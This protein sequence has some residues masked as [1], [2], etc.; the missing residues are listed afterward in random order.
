MRGDRGGE[1]SAEEKSGEGG[2]P[3][4]GWENDLTL[5]WEEK[6]NDVS[7]SPDFGVTGDADEGAEEEATLSREV[8]MVTFSLER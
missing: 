6:V 3:V 5:M 7:E 8:G 1:N 4:L 2:I